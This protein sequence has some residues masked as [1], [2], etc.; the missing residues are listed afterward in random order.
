MS[1]LQTRQLLPVEAYRSPDWLERERQAIF[2]RAWS[3]AGLE[4]DLEAPGDYRVLPAGQASLI[5]LRDQ[6]GAL[7]AFHNICRHRGTELLEGCGKLGRTIV[8]PY[9]KWSY[10][11]EGALLGMPEQRACFAGLDKAALGLHRAALACFKGMVFLHPDAEPAVAFE[12]WIG[13]LQGSLWPHDFAEMSEAPPLLYETRCNWK[14]FFENVVD[15]YHLAF[16]HENTLGGPK[17]LENV[18]ER[19]GRHLVWYSTEGGGK[20]CLPAAAAEALAQSGTTRIKGAESGSYP[21]VIAL[22]P[23]T[24]ITAS[25]YEFAVST[26]QPLGPAL[27]RIRTRGWGRRERSWFGGSSAASAQAQ[28]EPEV[29]RLEDLDK[30]PMESADFM[31]ED[32]WICEKIQRSIASRFFSVGALAEGPGCESPLVWFQTQVLQDLGET[33]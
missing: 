6:D 32:L 2:S 27:T 17:P 14:I 29:I 23:S 33:A 5:L 3:F 8:C 19:H 22:Y 21:G 1:D 7:R 18:W 24:F 16:L 9:H 30:H 12:D 20:S 15:G 10:D 28:A 31:L 26:L 11:L 4:S 13:A 25:P